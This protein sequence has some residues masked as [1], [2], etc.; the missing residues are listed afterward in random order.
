MK[1]LSNDKKSVNFDFGGQLDNWQ[2]E[3]ICQ[4]NSNNDDEI[5]EYLEIE[6]WNNEAIEEFIEFK[7]SELINEM[8][9]D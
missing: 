3:F 1:T 7:N 5:R 9:F 4:Q 6:D 8:I 2:V